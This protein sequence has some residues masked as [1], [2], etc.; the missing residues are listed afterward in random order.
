MLLVLKPGLYVKMTGFVTCGTWNLMPPKTINFLLNCLFDQAEQQDEY[1][2]LIGL[3]PK[4]WLC[5]DAGCAITTP[6][7]LMPPNTH[8]HTTTHLQGWRILNKN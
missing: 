8:T 7:L 6:K 2:Q 5:V 4:H 1:S 3:A